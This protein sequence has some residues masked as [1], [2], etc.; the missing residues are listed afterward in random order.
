[1]TQRQEVLYQLMLKV[2]DKPEGVELHCKSEYAAK[3]MRFRFYKL[4]QRMQ[5]ANHPEVEKINSLIFTLDGQK[6]I[7]RRGIMLEDL[8]IVDRATGENITGKFDFL[9]EL[10]AIDDEEFK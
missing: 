2:W 7:V 8:A 3:T 5:K 6:V 1:M 9:D 10:V 4:R